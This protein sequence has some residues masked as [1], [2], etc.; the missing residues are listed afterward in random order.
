MD[1]TPINALP[2]D[3]VMLKRLLASER[4]QGAWKSASLDQQIA[5]QRAACEQIKQEAANNIEAQR[6]K[7]EAQVAAL[8]RRF[9]GPKSE[10][11]D[12]GNCCSLGW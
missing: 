8:L 9:D 5:Q 3:P 12:P 2:D 6:Q 4:L 11:F 10:R 1:A 7:H